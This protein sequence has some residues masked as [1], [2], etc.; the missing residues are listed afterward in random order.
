MEYF[1]IRKIDNFEKYIAMNIINPNDIFTNESSVF[2]NSN[3]L[4]NLFMQ[5]TVIPPED[6]GIIQIPDHYDLIQ[7]IAKKSGLKDG[8]YID[9]YNGSKLE[10]SHQKK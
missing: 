1:G 4:D 3:H 2:H 7:F 8:E 9:Y 5:N 6:I 10:I